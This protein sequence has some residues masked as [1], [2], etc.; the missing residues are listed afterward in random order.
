MDCRRPSITSGLIPGAATR[1]ALAAGPALALAAALLLPGLPAAAAPP[2]A[3]AAPPTLRGPADPRIQSGIDL[4][5]SLR[6]DEAERYFEGLIAAHPDHPLG[7][8]FLAT[9][10]WWRILVDLEDRSHDEAFYKLLQRCIDVC[11]RRLEADPDDFDAILFKG[12]AI[13]FRGRLRGDRRQF[14]QA[15]RDGLRSLPL[16]EKSRRL[17]PENMDILFGQGVYNYFAEV[18]PKRHPVVRPVMWFLPDGDRELGLEQLRLVGREGRYARTEALYFLAQI[19]RLFEEDDAAALPYLRQLHERYPDNSLFHRYVGRALVGVDRWREGVAVYEEVE[20]RSR[21]GHPG[22]HARGRIEAL[23]YIGRNAQRHHRRREAVRA[24]A[25]ADSLSYGL[26]RKGE[27]QA[28]RGYVPLANLYLGILLDELGD[29]EAAGLRFRR[30][31]ELPD[32][33]GGGEG[34]SHGLARRYLDGPNRRPAASEPG[35]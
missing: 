25:A 30:V 7:H 9:V 16:L 12:G 5:Y 35:S 13:G 34:S 22:Y 8:F 18:I 14:L 3:G 4:I 33:R 29:P 24:L 11:D 17:E 28:V 23:Y 10:T 27:D 31:L 19:H 1:R 32:H 21:A 6:F 20:A 15:A 2:P 26:G